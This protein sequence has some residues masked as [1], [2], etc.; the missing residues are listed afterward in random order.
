M[1]AS[2]ELRNVMLRLYASLSTG[3]MSEIEKL[4]SHQE[5]IL[6]IGTDPDEWWAGYASFAC[7]HEAQYQ[8]M[9]GNYRIEAGELHAFV[10]GDVG[11][12]GDR[13]TIQMPDGQRIPIRMTC[14]FHREE[15]GWKVVQ[16]H[17]SVGAPNAEAFG[18]EFSEI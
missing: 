17:V 2:L 12:V 3:D 9:G 10:E 13:A 1:E 8:H 5:D 7:A 16:Q 11:W 14:V 18:V 6:V 15:G 4:Y